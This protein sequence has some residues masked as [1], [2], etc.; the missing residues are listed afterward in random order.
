MSSVAGRAVC[1]N[2]PEKLQSAGDIEINDT[3]AA[4]SGRE[5]QRSYTNLGVW[6]PFP[7]VF[8][9]QGVQCP[10]SRGTVRALGDWSAE[11]S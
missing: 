8:L 2:C 3:L 6:S 1:A 5:T 11:I 9:L 7:S 4:V 10:E